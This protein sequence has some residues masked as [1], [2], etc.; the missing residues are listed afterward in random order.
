[1]EH[2]DSSHAQKARAGRAQTELGWAG[3]KGGVWTCM[4]KHFRV[5]GKRTIHL[6][7][8]RMQHIQLQLPLADRRRSTVSTCKVGWWAGGLVC[9]APSRS[10][11]KSPCQD[12]LRLAGA[13]WSWAGGRGW[14]SWSEAA[15]VSSPA[16]RQVL[17]SIS[18][19][20]RKGQRLFV[21]KTRASSGKMDST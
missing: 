13:S 4:P 14:V 12:L 16:C 18:A 17:T 5:R 11:I 10:L 8:P 15:S 9:W 21:L 7:Q 2:R 6:K 3:L 1:L 20:Q 19:T